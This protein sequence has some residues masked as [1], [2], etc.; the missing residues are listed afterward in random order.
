MPGHPVSDPRVQVVLDI[1]LH[2]FLGVELRDPQ[3]P[4]AGIRFQVG[5]A[6]ENPAKLLHGGVVYALLDVAS[7]LALLPALGPDEHAVTHDVAASLL[8]PVSSG[9][10]VDIVGTVLR[11]GR[12]VAFMRAEASVDGVLVATGQVTKTVIQAR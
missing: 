5:A 1:P 11:R 9:A 10:T 3:D 8:R 7:F 4:A 12:A 2:R 6:S